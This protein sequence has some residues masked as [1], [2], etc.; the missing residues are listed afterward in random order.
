MGK[1]YLVLIAD[2]IKENLLLLRKIIESMDYNVQEAANGKEGLEIARLHKPDL[3]ISDILMPVMDGFQFCREVKEDEELKNIPFIFHTATYTD[4]KDKEF[5]LKLGADKFIIKPTEL[6]EFIKIIQGVTKDVEKG[7]IKPKKPSLNEEQEIFKLYS[8]RLV[9]KLEK[10]MLDLEKEITVRKRTEEKLKTSLQEKEIL[11]RE[12]YH[13]TKNNIQVISSMLRLRARSFKN[14]Q[15]TDILKEIE[16]K[17][18]GVALVHQKLYEA[19]DLSHLNLK[20]YLE[21]LAQILRQSLS[22][23]SKKIDISIK[24]ENIKVLLDTAMPCGIIINELVANSIKHAFPNN[25]K[26]KIDIRLHS[27]PKN[28][29]V[30]EISD[31]GVGLPKDFDINKDS[32]L[33]FQTILDLVEYQLDGK[34]SFEN[35]NG[36]YCRIVIKKGLYKPRV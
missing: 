34:V 18:L 22:A 15:L 21:G 33:G 26:G 23:S 16:N 11:L 1:K 27:K 12:L 8:E 28:E 5:A 30:L 14:Q 17:I 24:G 20:D 25:R 36:L 9:K 4:K 19:G 35:R 13:R 31:N 3:I 32:R 29:I 2:D 6:D 7:K 10:K